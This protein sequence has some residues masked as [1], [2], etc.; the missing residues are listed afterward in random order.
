MQNTYRA[1]HLCSGLMAPEYASQLLGLPIEW[2]FTSEINPSALL[3]Q[4]KNFPSIPCIGDLST[5]VESCDEPLD[6]V[7][8]GT[9]CQSFSVAGDGTGLEGKSGLLL[10]FWNFLKKHQPRSFIWENVVGVLR[11]ETTFK[12][13]LGAFT[14]SLT[15]PEASTVEGLKLMSVDGGKSGYLF[16]STD[17]GYNIAW[18]VLD[19]MDT[20]PQSRKRLYMIGFKEADPSVIFHSLI[21]SRI[22]SLV[23]LECLDSSLFYSKSLASPLSFDLLIEEPEN[24]HYLTSQ[25]LSVFVRNSKQRKIPH[26]NHFMEKDFPAFVEELAQDPQGGLRFPHSLMDSFSFKMIF[27]ETRRKPTNHYVFSQ[28]ERLTTP[29]LT[30]GGSCKKASSTPLAM[31][32]VKDH[33][34]F[35]RRL[36][37]IETERLMGFPAG[38]TD[39]VGLSNGARRRLVGNSMA[40]SSLKVVLEAWTEIISASRPRTLQY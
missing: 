16:A 25:A 29:C 10:E 8:A 31:F 30:V 9:P 21:N 14:G 28:R 5:A 34:L 17:A 23:N 22:R 26:S 6:L 18:I 19:A 11:D 2:K 37:L 20:S 13:I 38:W 36:T 32:Y 40:I 7:V 27:V 33:H 12:R 3:L 24:P 1:A 4:Q 35:C 39:G 15:L